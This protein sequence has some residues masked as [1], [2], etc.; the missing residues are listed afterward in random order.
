MSSSSET[1]GVV[2]LDLAEIYKQLHRELLIDRTELPVI[3]LPTL[4]TR[5]EVSRLIADSLQQ[6]QTCLARQ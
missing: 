2:C 6:D 3:T 4:S 5:A 1:R